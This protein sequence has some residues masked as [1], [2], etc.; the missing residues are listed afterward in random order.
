MCITTI[1]SGQA[2]PGGAVPSS[3]LS[4]EAGGDR[5]VLVIFGGSSESEDSGRTIS[6]KGEEL[7]VVI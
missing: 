4:I 7:F 3:S 5:A 6:N 1:H 2:E